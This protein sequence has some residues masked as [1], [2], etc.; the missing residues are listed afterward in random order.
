MALAA[1]PTTGPLSN[2]WLRRP[3]YPNT[4]YRL[5]DE[6]RLAFNSDLGIPHVLPTLYRDEQGDAKVRVVMRI[7]PWHDPHDHVSL[8]N[9][10]GAVVT[11]GGCEP[12][13]PQYDANSVLPLE[14]FKAKATIAFP[15]SLPAGTT[16]QV[17]VAPLEP[18]RAKL[19]NAVLGQLTDVKLGLEPAEVLDRIYEVAP[20]GMLDWQLAIDCPPLASTPVRPASSRS[21]RSMSRSPGEMAAVTSCT[22]PASMPRRS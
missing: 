5:S 19:W 14:I 11:V 16:V 13:L 6:L 22:S 1:N 2:G 9:K 10:S 18:D 8:T 7:L 12:R 17:G 21:S 4:I 3:G 15:V 20:V